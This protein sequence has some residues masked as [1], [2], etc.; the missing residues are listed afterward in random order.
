MVAALIRV[1]GVTG[2]DTDV[3]IGSVVTLSNVNDGNESTYTWQLLSQPS[4]TPDTLSSTS[5]SSPTFTPTREGSYLV[6][7]VVDQGLDSQRRNKVVVAV[8]HVRSGLRHPALYETTEVD[9]ATNVPGWHTATE[10]LWRRVDSLSAESC[11][12]VCYPG[13]GL[14]EGDCVRVSGRSVVKAGT[15]AEEYLPTAA[16]VTAASEWG[17]EWVGCVEGAVNGSE[18]PWTDTPVRVRV[19]GYV[20]AEQ[21]IDGGAPDPLGRVYLN[22]S[23]KLSRTP[24]SYRRPLGK[25]LAAVTG[26]F[27]V[28]FDGAPLPGPHVFGAGARATVETV[29]GWVTLGAFHYTSAKFANKAL[30]LRVVAAITTSGTTGQVRLFEPVGETTPAM[31]SFT[32]N[33][34]MAEEAVDEWTGTVNRPLLLQARLVGGSTGD[35]LEHFNAQVEVWNR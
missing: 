23:G 28:L 26:S 22:N 19:L 24:G 2:S 21:T 25:A 31:V 29:D 33:T 18:S 5:A 8:R 17:H 9:T 16:K 30:F 27:Y 34:T 15:P 14:E 10:D 4:G 7:L 3:P 13:E 35:T 1:N 6:S 20:A 32:D 12:F 11:V